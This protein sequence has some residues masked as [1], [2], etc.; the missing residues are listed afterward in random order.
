MF[1]GYAAGT[2]A[3]VV[4][5]GQNRLTAVTTS[6][7]TVPTSEEE[8][9]RASTDIKGSIDIFDD[10]AIH[11]IELA[12]DAGPY[13]RMIETFQR[14]GSKEYIEAS[15]TID[16]TR[17]GS[18]GIRLKGN[19]T[20]GALRRGNTG[21]AGPGG[22]AGSLSFAK[23]EGL[24]WLIHVDEF[25]KGQR[26]QEYEQLAIRPAAGAGLAEAVALRMVGAAGEPTQRSAY[27]AVSVNG[28]APVLRLVVE[29][30]MGEFADDNFEHDGV[31]YKALAGGSFTYRGDDPLA[32]EMSFKQ[33]TRKNHQDKKPLM[34]L[35]KWVTQ[36]SDAEFA[37]KLGDF[38]DV[39]SFGTYV[40]LQDLL[41]NFD[42][43]SG[44]GQ[45]Y[46][47][48]YD[49]ETGKFTVLTWDLNLAF[50]GLGRGGG[51]VVVVPPGGAP[52]ADAAPAGR[53]PAGGAPVGGPGLGGRGGNP[54]KR[55]FVANAAFAALRTQSRSAAHQA[56][57][58][59]GA[60]LGELARLE[61][62]AL[63]SGLLTAAT[64]TS[65]AASLRS[66]ISRYGA[67]G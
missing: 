45:N 27:A 60:A 55:R 33:V 25:A 46:Y 54:L 2:T 36:S 39:E 5:F 9:A 64:L 28:S 53:A 52:P 11:R 67:N 16:G 37:A 41:A 48:W 61:K 13:A 30:P 62:V 23:P 20:V 38:I 42:D 49:L 21:A 8:A 57:Y 50:G 34:N 35:M 6:E 59:S 22:T 56:I 3:L 40:A 18:A 58:G 63:S 12:Y 31:L 29:V 44:P 43:M 19:S 65:E 26:Y 14:D 47:L 66:T 32:Y 51:A 15:V 7:R 10:T 1:L 24:P 17:I 4:F